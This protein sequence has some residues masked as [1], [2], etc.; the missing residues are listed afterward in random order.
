MKGKIFVDSPFWAGEEIQFSERNDFDGI[1]TLISRIKTTEETK[2]VFTYMKN[3]LKKLAVAAV[4]ALTLSAP[5]M[6][7]AHWLSSAQ[8]KEIGTRAAADF[9]ARYEVSED[10]VLTH[11]QSRLMQYNSD[12]LWMYGTPGHKRGLEQ[13]LLAKSNS[14]NAISYGGGQIYIYKG[15]CD[16]LADKEPGSRNI[17]DE[18]HNPWKKS[19]I[20]QMSSLAAVMGHEMGHWENEDMLRMHDKQ[21]NTRLLVSLI[22]VG[23]IWAALGVAAGGNL[24][25]VFNS[26]QMGFRT[27]QQADEKAIEYLM[28][29]PEYSIGGEAIVHFRNLQ[30]KKIQGIE[31][32]VT[33]WVR[34]HSKDGK[35]LERVLK[36][37]EVQSNGFL[38]WEGLGLAVDGV[39][40]GRGLYMTVPE[41]SG[42]SPL[43]RQFFVYG[44]IATAIHYDIFKTYNLRVLPENE[45]FTDG[46]PQNATLLC[47]GRDNTGR[48]RM[49]IMD[50]YRNVS[51]QKLDS[52]LKMSDAEFSKFYDAVSVKSEEY[53]FA[54]IR[55]EAA[56]YENVRMKYLTNKVLADELSSDDEPDTSN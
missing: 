6:A 37:Q 44:Q 29:V 27:E 47:E 28:E 26:R 17:S 4:A 20:Y 2:E 46:S 10:P 7:E 8:E 19:N 55:R 36:A 22:P 14:I 30:Y 23:N 9:A 1:P 41:N 32:R 51:A 43:E 45:V 49:K 53:N 42:L 40:K 39:L 3:S 56:N 21:M 48:N 52:I 35:R 50:T 25:N 34:P 54:L 38:K 11:I 15:M 33:D 5:Y 16:L 24:I 18:Y 31:D 12:K 13:V